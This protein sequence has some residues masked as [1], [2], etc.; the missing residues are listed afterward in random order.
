MKIISKIYHVI[1]LCFLATLLHSCASY[2]AQK[3]AQVSESISFKETENK[4]SHQFILVGDAGNA[5]EP[6]AIANLDFISKK[7]EDADKNTTVLF[8][9]DNIYPKGLP[10]VG[11]KNRAEAEIKINNQLKMV[12]NFKGNTVFIPGNHDWY[13]G[14]QGLIDQKEY[15][16]TALNNKKA[17]LPRKYEAIDKLEIND[18]I[19]LIVV[20]SEWFLQDWNKH[21]DINEASEI[22]TR[23]D[24]FEEFRSLVNKNQN[25]LTL[26]VIHHPIFSGGP[27]GGYFSLRSHLF[28]Y[29]NI[30]LPV[31]GTIGNY[32]RK[33]TGASP[34]DEQFKLYQ[35]LTKRIKTIVSGQDQ[36]IFVSGHD[37]NLQYI[38]Q[39]GIKQ[40]I[41]GSASKKEEIRAIQPVSF[42]IG[43]IGYGILNV[44]ENKDAVVSFYTTKD[45]VEELVFNRL[46]HQEEKFDKKFDKISESTKN[47]SVYNI[48]ETKKSV[49]YKFLFGKHYRDVYGTK[50][51]AP[52]ANLDTL[53]GGLKPTISGGGNQS[54]S[55][56]LE[57][58]NGKEF[59]M[60]GLRKSST[61]FLQSAVFKD[62][63]VKEKLQNTYALTFIDDYY[64]T[65]HPFTPF[66]IG[67]LSDAIELHH[68]NPKL[69]YVP[70]QNVLGKYNENYGDELYMIE[71]RPSDTQT[72]APN[73][74]KPDDIVSTKDMLM[75]L[76][77]DEKYVVD[78][79]MYLK[80]RIFD[81]LIGDWDRHA[82][83]WR[84]SV[85]KTQDSVLYQPIARD[86]DQA[87]AKIDG[88]LLSLLKRTPPLRHMQSFKSNFAN[89]RWITKTAFPLDKLLLQDLNLEDWKTSAQQIVNQISDEVIAESFNLL[90]EEVQNMESDQIQMI[91]KERR[92]KLI[93]F[94]EVYYNELMKYGV[95]S[96]TNKK[97]KFKITTS[98][99]N[100]KVEISRLKKTGE[101][102]IKTITYDPKVTKE[103]WIYTLD[104]D[105]EI[106]VE[107]EKSPILLRLIGGRNNDVYEISSESKIK[108]YDFASKTNT[109][110]KGKNTKL[111]LRYNHQLNNF[112]YRNA[113]LNT[114]TLMPSLGY[115]RDNGVML[116]VNGTFTQQKFIHQP[117]NQKHQLKA[118]IDFATNGARIDYVG[119]FKNNSRNWYYQ[120]DATATSSNFTQ[121]YFGFG[122]ETAYDGELFED[123]YN[124]VRTE[125][126]VFKPSYNYLGRNGGNFLVGLTFES[127]KIVD[128][129]N[130]FIDQNLISE[131]E[132]YKAQNFYGAQFKYKFENYNS[133]SNPSL[134]LGFMLHYGFR[135]NTQ[136]FNDNHSFVTSKLNVV[137]PLVAKQNIT[138]SSSLYG[139]KMVGNGYHFYQAADLGS[140]TYLRGFRQNRFVGE[141]AFAHSND[142]NFKISDLNKGIIPVSYGAFV[143][144]D[145]GRVWQPNEDS[146]QWHTSYGGGLWLNAIE[147]LTVKLHVFKSKEELMYTFGIGFGF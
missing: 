42:A 54:L 22:K 96:G 31:L 12:E 134:G 129:E 143:G 19:T 125:Q 53:Y 7:I 124:R 16:A 20:D 76:E 80:A 115:N 27:H 87:F 100:L 14:L 99:E 101:L 142:V 3:G 147:S 123:N 104:D 4:L 145:Y 8:L 33:T 5:D 86:R 118:N 9:G 106:Y 43:E 89:P 70:K 77:K 114:Y 50:V 137:V 139:K 56:R 23:E 117:F 98:K 41:S 39:D 36:V 62:I 15:I 107:G 47:A 24:F 21:A 30:P 85:H 35:D 10:E 17:F 79:K 92:S 127:T 116:G 59:V 61:Q 28:P 74:G 63:Y 65:S 55:L 32:L 126:Y 29:K 90:P 40:I 67:N 122:N 48:E 130:R 45:G 11:S 121:N 120:I 78:S 105:D 52:V 109:I 84:W 82:D 97:D 113:P 49:F 34:A 91:L 144:F 81:F 6:R 58:K 128:T 37:H 112:D 71:E 119:K 140:N 95:I 141:S 146:S 131:K 26:V 135:A 103:V 2:Q 66:I 1:I 73:F 132:D 110:N 94:V 93:D 44:Y 46:I 60:R 64:T 25:K 83:Q 68:S 57:D 111:I 18:D 69:F 133:N 51:Q 13:S 72:D 108:L 138:L 38:E 136:Q 75:S 88:N 102:P